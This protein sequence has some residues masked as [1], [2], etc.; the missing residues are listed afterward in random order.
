MHSFYPTSAGGTM[1]YTLTAHC[2]KICS[3][4]QSVGKLCI[5]FVSDQRDQH[6]KKEKSAQRRRKHCPLAIVRRSQKKIAPPQ[7]PF[8]GVWDGQNLIS[9]R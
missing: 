8:P 3:N 5:V 9:W 1:R 6:K 7:T 4:I 2:A